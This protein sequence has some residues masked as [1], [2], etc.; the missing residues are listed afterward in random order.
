MNGNMQLPEV[1]RGGERESLGSP[2]DLRWGRHPRVNVVTLAEMPNRDM[3]PKEATLSSQIGFPV[4]GR[5]HQ[6][7]YK[8]SN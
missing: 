4:E 1:G 6:P 3:E 5:G 2:R 8:T 7:S